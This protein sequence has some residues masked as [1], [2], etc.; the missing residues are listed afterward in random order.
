MVKSNDLSDTTWGRQLKADLPA[1]VAVFLVALPLCMGIAIAS[2][3]PVAA[4][5]ITGIVG[6]LVVGTLGGSPLQ[7]SGP[8]AGLT[9]VVFGMVQHY[10]LAGLGWIVLGAGLLQLLAGMLKLGQWFRAVSPAVIHGMLAGIGVLIFAS[11]F[12]VMV[13]DAP[14]DS[15]IENLVTIPEAIAKGLPLPQTGTADERRRRTEL[16]KEAS[17]LRERQ[18]GVF[19]AIVAA[20]SS[21]ESDAS[22]PPADLMQD[23]A[24]RQQSITAAV[25]QLAQAIN[26]QPIPGTDQSVAMRMTNLAVEHSRD[27]LATMT[28]DADAQSLL[29]SQQ[30]A[31]DSLKGIVAELKSHKWAAKVGLLTIGVLLCWQTLAPK[32]LRALPAPLLAVVVAGIFAFLWKLPILYVS[33]PDSLW[34]AIRSPSFSVFDDFA[35]FDLVQASVVI[36]M[37]A[38]AETLL[39]ATAVDKMHNGRGTDYDRELCAQGIG[40]SLCGLFGALPMT[41]VIVRSAS[42]VQAGAS[43]RLSAILHGVWLVVFVSL[44]VP[45]LR[46]IPVACLAAVLVFTGYKLVNLRHLAELRKYGWGEVVIYLAT[47][48]MIVA[49]DLLT[50]V[51]VGVG[52]SAVKLLY[53]FSHL[54]AGIENDPQ[55]NRSVLALQGAATFLRLPVL[56]TTLQKV[57]ANAELHV[58]LQRLDYID[59]ACIDLLMSWAKQ[60]EKTGGSLVIDW[61]TLHAQFRREHAIRKRSVA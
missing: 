12:H 32:R 28:A 51:L 33:V 22:T 3:A 52:L 53:T 50:G 8:A 26:S 43:T 7:V 5:L 2:G 31:R 38:S 10:G 34:L 54:E 36:A 9:V 16:L 27:A 29:Q 56:A 37:I 20:T 14:K 55:S 47:L 59:H 18:S 60:H 6:G 61:N 19:D 13:D 24:D 48:T 23:L 41:G 25:N 40:N 15:G 4:G 58:D 30:A 21:G 46:A 39:C 17:Q 11:Q 1:S 57:P 49:T 44:L 35:L 42:N 45:V